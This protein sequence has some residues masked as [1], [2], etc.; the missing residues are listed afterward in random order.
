MITRTIVYFHKNIRLEA[1]NYTGKRAYFLTQCCHDR[2]KHFAN[3]ARCEWL[4]AHLRAISAAYSFA[5]PAYCIMPNHMHLLADGL[6]PTSDF[7]RFIKALK[8]KTSR[9][10]AVGEGAPFWQK[11]YFDHILRP[12]D[13]MDSGA[14]YIWLNQVRAPLAR[15]PG[16]KPFAGSFTTKVRTGPTGPDFWVQPCKAAHSH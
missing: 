9:E 8:I 3:P 5:I 2:R 4:L 7:L 10:F 13:S 1:A 15:G 6:L 12:T 16:I 11:K 14:W